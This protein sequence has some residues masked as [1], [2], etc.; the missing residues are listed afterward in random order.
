MRD[1]AV[2]FFT[3]QFYRTVNSIDDLAPGIYTMFSPP[4]DF[5]VVDLRCRFCYEALTFVGR[6]F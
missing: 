6:G 1:T 4:L 2:T 3:Q 5:G